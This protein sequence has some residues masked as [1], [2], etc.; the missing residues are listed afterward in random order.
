MRIIIV[1]ASGTIGTAVTGLLAERHEVIGVGRST[2]PAVDLGDPGSVAE[3]FR[4]VGPVDGVVACTGSVPF[5]PWAEL[6]EADYRSGIDSKLIG[7][8]TLA[9][10]AATALREGGSITLTSGVL[11]ADPIPTG[12]AASVANAGIEAFVR[13]S[14]GAIGRG[15][16]INAISP[17]VLVESP[18]FHDSFPGFEPVPAARV[19]Q[20]YLRS[21]E[22]IDTGRILAVN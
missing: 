6:D 10:H 22:G 16:R 2:T 19:A 14:A 1:G 12:T 20:A 15:I 3:L 13:T 21:V 4:S 9:R 18:Q 7:Q 5:K 11:T 17:G 8:I